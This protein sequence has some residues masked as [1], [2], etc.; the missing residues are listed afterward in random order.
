MR[1]YIEKR[2]ATS[3]PFSNR[4]YPSSLNPSLFAKWPL[5][6]PAKLRT[7]DAKPTQVNVGYYPLAF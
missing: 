2:Q 5:V 3:N 6:T 4:S 7:V 1:E